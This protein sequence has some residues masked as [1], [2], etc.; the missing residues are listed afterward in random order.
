LGWIKG[1]VTKVDGVKAALSLP[2]AAMCKDVSDVWT[3]DYRVPTL[4]AGN[5]RERYSG[6]FE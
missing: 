1:V 3:H 5:L 2:M 4:I 6:I